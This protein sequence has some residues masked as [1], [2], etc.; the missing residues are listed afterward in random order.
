MF[1]LQTYAF[2]FRTSQDI[3]LVHYS[4]AGIAINRTLEETTGEDFTN[5]MRINALS[6][7]SDRCIIIHQLDQPLLVASL[8]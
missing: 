7:V 5:T 1:S 4:Q 6:Y 3:Q 8:P 2:T